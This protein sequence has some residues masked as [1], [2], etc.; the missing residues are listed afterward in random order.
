MHQSYFLS[1][2]QE[3]GDQQPPSE[4]LVLSEEYSLAEENDRLFELA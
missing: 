1:I 2:N 3:I 4:E